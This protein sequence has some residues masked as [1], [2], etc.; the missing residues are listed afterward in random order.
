MSVPR[1]NQAFKFSVIRAN[2]YASL[3][4]SWTQ[5]LT[6]VLYTGWVKSRHVKPCLYDV[7]KRNFIM[8]SALQNRSKLTK[9]NASDFIFEVLDF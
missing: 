8:V 6:L 9:R 7:F 3:H 2:L 4:S 5:E 1:N